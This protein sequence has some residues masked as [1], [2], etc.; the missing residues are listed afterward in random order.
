VWVITIMTTKLRVSIVGDGSLTESIIMEL[1]TR[2][3]DVVPG[4]EIKKQEKD[5][6]L[7]IETT[8]LDLD[9]KKKNLQ[10]IEPFIGQDVLILTTCL[11]VTATESASWLKYPGRLVGFAAFAPWEGAELIEV[12]PALQTNSAYLDHTRQFFQLLGK[13]IEI[14]DDEVGLV[15]PRILSLIINE[16]VFALTEGIASVEDIDTA[17]IHGTNY[18]MGPLAWADEIGIDDVYAVLAGLYRNLGEDRYRPAP[19]LRKMVHA[20]WLGKKSGK[21]FYN[22]KIEE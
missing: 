10:E 18:P 19:Q 3:H 5:I 16:A 7:V 9:Q 6:D 20:G 12:A 8:N 15:F 2:G 4:N 17:M 21:G 13:E 22:Y 11:G 14:V 1:K